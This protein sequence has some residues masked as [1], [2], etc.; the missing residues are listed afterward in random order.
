[1]KSIWFFLIITNS[2]VLTKPLSAQEVVIP[3]LKFYESRL[4]DT[5][6][7]TLKSSIEYPEEDG[8][9][10]LDPTLKK[11][12]NTAYPRG[13]NDGPV[14]KG[15]G[16]T[17]EI[18]GGIMG[19]KGKFS[20]AFHPVVFYSQ[21]SGF[22]LAPNLDG[23]NNIYNYQYTSPIGTGTIDW[24]QRYG[25]SP[26]AYFATGQSE[27]RFTI[28]NFS[29][30]ISSSNFSLGPSVFNPIILS[31]QAQG[32]PRI[33]LEISPVDLVIKSKSI[34]TIEGA[35]SY[36][37]LK[38]SKYF[39][40]NKAD[41]FRYFN[42]YSI[43][44][45]PKILS[46]N[47]KFGFQKSLYNRGEYFDWIDL[48]AP[49]KIPDSDEFNADTL[50]NDSFDQLASFN[51]EWHFP[52]I[53][54]RAYAEFAKNDFTGNGRWTLQE[55]EHTRA[56]TLG[57]EKSF[58]FKNGVMIYSVYEHSNLSRNHTYLWRAAPSYYPHGINTQGYTNEGQIIGAGIGPGSNSDQVNI[59][60]E[61]KDKKF[62]L[63]AQRIENNKDYFVTNVHTLN[64]HDVEYSQG[65]YYSQEMKRLRLQ[66]E[67]TRSK[68]MN[69]YWIMNN[70]VVNYYSSISLQYKINRAE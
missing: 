8:L 30:S 70:D 14:W 51:M 34:L 22:D 25:S 28:W 12:Y 44:L 37:Y 29:T 68:N 19:K 69:R 26:F 65:I 62:G 43:G 64:Q 55:P 47:L 54:F 56:Y 52:S 57:F 18:H 58:N 33:T 63:L 9:W 53:G 16:L 2:F 45:V 35:L 32:I 61:Y 6:S 49:F 48:T 1:M 21:N 11:S 23:Q 3:G 67:L 38:E 27:I 20:F 46:N 31:H 15:R 39:N 36:G 24:V 4:S 42:F 40:S 5:T 50:N 66:F 17:S 60:L 10:I 7:I 13:F 59:L 41:N